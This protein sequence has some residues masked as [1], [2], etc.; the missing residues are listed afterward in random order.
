[1]TGWTGFV[2]WPVHRHSKVFRLPLKHTKIHGKQEKSFPLVVACSYKGT[3]L[4]KTDVFEVFP[5]RVFLGY[6]RVRFSKDLPEKP[7]ILTSNKMKDYMIFIINTSPPVR[8]TFHSIVIPHGIHGEASARFAASKQRMRLS[9]SGAGQR[10]KKRP[11]DNHSTFPLLGTIK[12]FLEKVTKAK[13]N[14]I[15]IY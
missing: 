14:K 15:V 6:S 12:T 8:T 13:D 1:M 5:G 10:T 11:G 9:R 4:E 2:G 3:C 7:Q